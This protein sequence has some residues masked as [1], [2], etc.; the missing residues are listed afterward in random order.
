MPS[1]EVVLNGLL[2]EVYLSDSG[3]WGND[4]VLIWDVFCDVS[5]EEKEII[6]QYLFDEGFIS[7]RRTKCQI[8]EI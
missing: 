5:D 3:D 4:S 2:I 7:D 1:Y 8:S 6:M